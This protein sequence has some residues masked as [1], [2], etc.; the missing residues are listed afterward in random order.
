MS[1]MAIYQS[2]T[3]PA[4]NP[5]A[6]RSEPAIAAYLLIVTKAISPCDLPFVANTN[7]T[8]PTALVIFPLWRQAAMPPNLLIVTR[9]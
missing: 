4:I 8:L 1:S 5:F 7:P 3:C 2:T 9:T 6:L